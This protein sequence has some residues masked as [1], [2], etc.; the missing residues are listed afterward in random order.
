MKEFRNILLALAW[1]H[2]RLH[3]GVARYARDHRWHLNQDL[4]YAQGQGMDWAGDG[5]ITQRDRGLFAPH[6]CEYLD[7]LT[8]PRVVIGKHVRS[9]NK[10]IAE[11]AVKFFVEH[12]Y[13]HMALIAPSQET[14]VSRT[15]YF[16]SECERQGRKCWPLI[17]PEQIHRGNEVVRWLARR[18]LEI[19]KPAAA[20]AIDDN[21][22]VATLEAAM[23]VDLH[24]PDDVAVL[25]VRNDEL[26]CD[27]A[28]VSL[29]SIDSD[30]EGLGYQAAALLDQILDGQPLPERPVL[31]PP[32]RIVERQST[33]VMAV[34]HP[35]LQLALRFIRD[36][37]RERI[38]IKDI[39]RVSAMSTRGLYKAFQ[40]QMNMTV[41]EYITQQRL[42]EAERM[43]LDTQASVEDIANYC[44]FG[45]YR[46]F[47]NA[48]KKHKGTT[49]K[50]WRR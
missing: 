42:A 13:E 3:L 10:M 29:S 7:G 2:P 20:F 30:L 24:V 21:Y 4:A 11:M 49:P 17:I 16:E 50:A 38:N 46:N 45:L 14:V 37:Y 23:S 47:Y 26:L 41:Y 6:V 12:G 8:V 27:T 43:L 44:G 32:L 5:L 15:M 1:Y 25:G 18:L 39:A 9:D 34:D 19:P 33:N 22:A 35:N 31:I 40:R 36:H 48:F 28:P